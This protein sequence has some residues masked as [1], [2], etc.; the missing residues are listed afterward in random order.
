MEKNGIIEQVR[1]EVFPSGK[2]AE[3]PLG[4]YCDHTVLRAYTTR[5]TVKQFCEEA[6]RYGAASVCV[7]PVHVAYVHELLR[8]TGLYTCTVIGFPL[9]AN[10]SCV[11]AMEAALAVEDGADDDHERKGADHAFGQN[12]HVGRRKNDGRKNGEDLPGHVEQLEAFA[13]FGHFLKSSSSGKLFFAGGRFI[14]LKSAF[15]VQRE[16]TRTKNYSRATPVLRAASATAFATAGTTR[17]SNESAMIWSGSSS[18]SGIS[19]ASA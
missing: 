3:K 4:K 6:V 11:K 9:G 2:A 15:S 14:I 19:A 7:N 5:E 1:E 10:R 8:G 12:S 16:Q 13:F 18:S 17:L